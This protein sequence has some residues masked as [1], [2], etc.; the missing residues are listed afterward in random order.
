ML[1]VNMQCTVYTKIDFER[2]QDLITT[3]LSN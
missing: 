2:L 1:N 3:K